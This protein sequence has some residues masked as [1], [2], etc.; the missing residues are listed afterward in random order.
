MRAAP[1]ANDELNAEQMANRREGVGPV[2]L[3]APGCHAGCQPR[4]HWANDEV[5]WRRG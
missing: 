5:F 1:G 4:K 2:P 3:G